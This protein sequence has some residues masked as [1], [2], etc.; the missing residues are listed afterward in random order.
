MFNVEDVLFSTSAAIT[1]NLLVLN[2]HDE[3]RIAA[4]LAE[5]V[6]LNEPKTM[7][8]TESPIHDILLIEMLSKLLLL[9]FSVKNCNDICLIVLECSLGAQ[10]VSEEFESV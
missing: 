6:L 9:K 1:Q 8:F 10:L 2:L 7:H 5:Y 3:L 4:I